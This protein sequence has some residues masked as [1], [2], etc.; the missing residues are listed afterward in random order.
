[1]DPASAAIRAVKALDCHALLELL[2]KHPALVREKEG[3]T[4]LEVALLAAIDRLPVSEEAVYVITSLLQRQPDVN[5]SSDGRTP[6]HLACCIQH[7]GIVNMLLYAGADANATYQGDTPLHVAVKLGSIEIMQLLVETNAVNVNATDKHGLT[8]LHYAVKMGKQ[9]LIAN[10]LTSGAHPADADAVRA[11]APSV[12]AKMGEL[13]TESATPGVNPTNICGGLSAIDFAASSGTIVSVEDTTVSQSREITAKLAIAAG[14]K[15]SY[16]RSVNPNHGAGRFGNVKLDVVNGEIVEKPPL[17]TLN[18]ELCAFLT[19]KSE[20]IVE[21]R[22][23][24]FLPTGQCQLFLEYMN[25]GTLRDHMKNSNKLDKV[26][27]ALAIARGLSALHKPKNQQPNG[28]AQWSLV[29]ANLKPENVLFNEQGEIKLAGLD[30]CCV[31]STV[32][33]RDRHSV[34]PYVAPEVKTT[35][36]ISTAADIYALGVVLSEMDMSEPARKG[37]GT[38]VPEL[39]SDCAEWYRELVQWCVAKE[40]HNRPKISDVIHILENPSIESLRD[41]GAEHL[42]RVKAHAALQKMSELPLKYQ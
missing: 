13:V 3:H 41:V 15:R 40:P 16:S 12:N 38:H 35:T 10:L 19:A 42:A 26:K 24:E 27:I 18:N 28:I 9:E 21:M 39:R 8:P 4:L 30:L 36:K 17:R 32:V 11:L 25:D 20:Y 37:N 22:K 5:V 31:E 23:V 7:E 34:D 1:M 33:S 2:E 14:Y 29:H 6:L